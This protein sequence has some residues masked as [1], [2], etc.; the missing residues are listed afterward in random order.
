[1]M[2]NKTKTTATEHE[3]RPALAPKLP[4]PEFRAAMAVADPC[5]N[6]FLHQAHR[7]P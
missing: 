7:M 3:A 1:M 6:V 4:F 5:N 2:G